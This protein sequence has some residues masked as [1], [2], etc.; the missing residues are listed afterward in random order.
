VTIP[1]YDD[2]GNLPP[3]LYRVTLEEIR[4]HFTWNA[5]RKRLFGG[6]IR[7]LK[8]LA[9]AGVKKVWIDGSFVTDKNE[10]ADI[11]GCW[12]YHES[13]DVNRLD[14]VFL[15]LNPPRTSMRKKYGVDFLISTV[16]L[17]DGRG[18]TVL[19]F[20]QQDRDGNQKGILLVEIGERL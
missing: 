18:N 19:E 8:N 7:A 16:S 11:D 20:F 13:V 2:N 10:P 9:E 12:E 1:G 6:L 14:E 5:K 4:N 3:G 15:D 17:L